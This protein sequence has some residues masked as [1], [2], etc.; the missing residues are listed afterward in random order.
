MLPQIY[1]GVII[2]WNIL[3]YFLKEEEILKYFN[4]LNQLSSKLQIKKIKNWNNKEREASKEE[5]PVASTSQPPQKGK[6]YKKNNLRKPYSQSYM[7]PIIQKYDIENFLNMARTLIYFKDKEEL[8]M[9][10]PHFPRK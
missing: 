4:E 7:I 8:G 10:Q 2:S 3:K 1:Q 9:R 6:K 5:A